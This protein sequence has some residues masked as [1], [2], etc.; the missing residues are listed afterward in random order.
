M[1]LQ[2]YNFVC[3]LLHYSKT[4]GRSDGYCKDELL[5]LARA[6]GPQRR[7]RCRAGSDAIVDHND[8]TTSDFNS[9]TAAQIALAPPFDLSELTI[10]DRIE[11]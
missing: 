4:V 10:A 6:G 8:D 1:S 7:A 2:T 11:F 3:L 9:F 5:R